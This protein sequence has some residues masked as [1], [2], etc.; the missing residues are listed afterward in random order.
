MSRRSRGS[1]NNLSKRERGEGKLKTIIGLAILAAM[2][3]LGFKI[4][5]AYINNFE[6]EDAMK[7]EAR[8]GYVNRKTPEEVRDT[9]YKK[10]QELEIPAGRDD[11]RVEMLANG[12]RIAVTYT[13][14]V[15]L[16]GYQLELKFKPTADNMS[17]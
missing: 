13:V 16:P 2:V 9:V 12:M 7:S 4:I 3:Y 6:L 10:I 17:I 14:V 5:P 15:E 1:R 11:I 8:F